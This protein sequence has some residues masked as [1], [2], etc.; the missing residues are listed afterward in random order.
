MSFIFASSHLP[1]VKRPQNDDEEEEEDLQPMRWSG[2]VRA[3]SHLQ[4]QR[5]DQPQASPPPRAAQEA[6]R[7]G[8][9]SAPAAAPQHQS[10]DA[11]TDNPG[12]APSQQGWRRR[13]AVNN[14]WEQRRAAVLQSTG[15]ERQR[16]KDEFHFDQ[17]DKDGDGR[18][19]AHEMEGLSDSAK[20]RFNILN[21]TDP[22]RVILPIGA[23]GYEQV[24]GGKLL[25]EAM[26]GR[27][28]ED[29]H[30]TAYEI[31]RSGLGGF[32]TMAVWSSPTAG[33]RAPA[34]VPTR[35]LID[36]KNVRFTQ[37]SV[38]ANFKNGQSI[39]DTAAAL[40]GP[41]GPQITTQMPPIKVVQ[42]EGQL[43]SLD[44]RRL[45][46]FAL[47]RQQIPYRPAT[48]AEIKAEWARK[49]TTNAQQGWGEIISVRPPKS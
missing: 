12:T 8:Q 41:N 48:P 25:R 33:V 1:E 40:K 27:P 4:G 37:N 20:K 6:P 24:Y 23:T 47:A 35:D 45:S 46:T 14:D 2:S 31:M 11:R 26:Q 38:S 9:I 21:S 43:F 30:K 32:G 10:S 28:A 7:Q 44:N 34:P 18:V 49:F 36:P 22:D 16:L 29:V 5:H 15:E 42:H 17:L 3:F 19:Y 39:N 13:T